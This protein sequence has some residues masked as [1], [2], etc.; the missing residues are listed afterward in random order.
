MEHKYHFM[1]TKCCPKEQIFD[2]DMT[3]TEARKFMDEH[4]S[5]DRR[6]VFKVYNDLTYKWE[7]GGDSYYG[8][9]NVYDNHG[10]HYIID[11]DYRNMWKAKKQ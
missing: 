7:D 2:G 4:A 3:F 11:P 8:N 5:S 1:I 10:Q 6:V 9:R